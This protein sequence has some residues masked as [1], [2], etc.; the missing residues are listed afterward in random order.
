MK[1]DPR[2]IIDTSKDH[3]FNPPA[4]LSPSQYTDLFMAHFMKS[5]RDAN[6]FIEENSQITKRI[7]ESFQVGNQECLNEIEKIENSEAFYKWENPE[8]VKIFKEISKM[9]L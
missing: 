9:Y 6:E 1:K 4:G 7:R 3:T 8:F 2:T 5:R